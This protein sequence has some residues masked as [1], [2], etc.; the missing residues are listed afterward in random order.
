M[1][2]LPGLLELRRRPL[3]YLLTASRQGGPLVPLARIPRK[4]FLVN[5][6]AYLRHI[7][8]DRPQNYIKGPAVVSIR[9]LFGTGLT[10]SD[11]A[12]WGR[13]RRLLFPAYQPRQIPD[14]Q[15]IV[16]DITAAMLAR[17]QDR[18]RRG[19]PIDIAA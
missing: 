17:W 18:I 9:P 7:L 2:E 6:P 11:G 8:Q 4:V 3:A 16:R 12:L 1:R 15:G 13:Q 10:T 14:L 5:D 19:E